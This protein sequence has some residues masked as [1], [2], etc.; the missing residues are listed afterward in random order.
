MQAVRM[1]GAWLNRPVVA[2]MGID[3]LCR[4]QTSHERFQRKRTSARAMPDLT[5]HVRRMAMACIAKP[6]RNADF[7]FQ[8]RQI[9]N[10]DRNA[11]G[12]YVVPVLNT[13]AMSASHQPPTAQR[14]I[15]SRAASL[16]EDWSQLGDALC[17]GGLEVGP[18]ATEGLQVSAGGNAYQTPV[19]GW[20]HDRDIGM[21]ITFCVLSCAPAGRRGA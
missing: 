16:L 14:K 9:G 2:P 20:H 17:A 3:G 19:S 7:R 5:D 4:V 18:L 10:T 8:C 15:A 1:I 12:T 13:P 6:T 21:M 11:L